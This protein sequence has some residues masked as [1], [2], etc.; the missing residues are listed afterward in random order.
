MISLILDI[1]IIV[2]LIATMAAG[3][4]FYQKLKA[5]RA[6]TE[7]L[8]TL[9]EALDKAANRA[10]TVLPSLRELAESIST[11][12]SSEA[13]KTQGLVDE[14]DFMNK[15]ADQLADKLESAISTARQYDKPAQASPAAISPPRPQKLEKPERPAPVHDQRRRVPDLEKRL[16]TLR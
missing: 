1:A 4:Q 3:Y 5:F 9:I 16:K 8:Q 10:E 7:D 12:L 14:L 11:K 6:E 2:L 13:T 15:R